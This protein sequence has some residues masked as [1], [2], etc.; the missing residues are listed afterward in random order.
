MK[1]NSGHGYQEIIKER[2]VVDTINF[3]QY[4]PLDVT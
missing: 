3:Q 4:S 2:G 1:K